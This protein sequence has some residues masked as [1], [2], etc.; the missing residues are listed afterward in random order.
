M[1]STPMPGPAGAAPVA[2]AA[3]SP[4]DE[5]LQT[6]PLVPR[7]GGEAGNFLGIGQVVSI[8]VEDRFVADGMVDTGAMHPI[9]RGGYFDYFHVT[10]ESRFTMRRPKGAAEFTER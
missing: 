8:Y 2:T 5:G 7:D 9:M 4:D 6:G 1:T 10:A 3:D